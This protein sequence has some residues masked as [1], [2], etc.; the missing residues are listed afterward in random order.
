MCIEIQQT[1]LFYS[2]TD[3]T[4]KH[5]TAKA[6]P[7]VWVFRINHFPAL[8]MLFAIPSGKFTEINE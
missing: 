2:Y 5:A 3:H 6:V 8:A 7:L 4:H 1:K